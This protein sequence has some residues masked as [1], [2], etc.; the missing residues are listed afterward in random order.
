MRFALAFLI[1]TAC[2]KHEPSKPLK[3]CMIS[4]P[5]VK[6]GYMLV[7]C[8]KN[9]EMVFKSYRKEYSLQASDE[10]YTGEYDHCEIDG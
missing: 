2:A 10:P 7:R 4:K 1:L 8:W 5:K 6:E 9:S 3:E